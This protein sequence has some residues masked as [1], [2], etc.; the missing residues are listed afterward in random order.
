MHR[1]TWKYFALAAFIAAVLILLYEG[2]SRYE[3]NWEE[4]AEPSLIQRPFRVPA[5]LQV[6]KRSSAKALEANNTSTG[7]ADDLLDTGKL[8]AE[9]LKRSI[10]LAEAKTLVVNKSY[11]AIESQVLEIDRRVGAGIPSE[12]VTDDLRNVRHVLFH[13]QE[14]QIVVDKLEEATGFIE[15][16]ASSTPGKLPIDI[17]HQEQG[18][19][20]EVC[21][22]SYSTVFNG[23]P[24]FNNTI[25][26]TTVRS[27]PSTLSGRLH[28]VELK[29]ANKT[30][31]ID[32]NDPILLDTA[33]AAIQPQILFDLNRH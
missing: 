13:Y 21:S 31:E 20:G 16:I 27:K 10:D 30:E 3:I 6:S 5:D 14:S 25:V 7:A 17:L 12:L 4:L 2:F 22:Y 26:L 19:S 28:S 1:S 8:I 24:I 18:C 29:Y 9:R 15:Q 33:R 23:L 11:Q 32:I